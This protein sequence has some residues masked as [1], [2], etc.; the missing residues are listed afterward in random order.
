VIFDLIQMMIVEIHNIILIITSFY[1][2]GK[3]EHE[4]EVI[5][6]G[7][8]DIIMTITTVLPYILQPLP[9]INITIIMLIITTTTT[10]TIGQLKEN[11]WLTRTELKD[12]GYEKLMNQKD[13]QIAMESMLGQRKL[14]TGNE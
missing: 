9:T 11:S 10:T 4:Y 6:E 1:I 5:W 2:S 3:R 8:N 14:T 12:M 7:N 13:E